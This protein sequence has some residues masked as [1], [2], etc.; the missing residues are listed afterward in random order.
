MQDF[1]DTQNLN[2]MALKDDDVAFYPGSRESSY[3]VLLKPKAAHVLVACIGG[4]SWLNFITQETRRVILIDRSDL[5]VEYCRLILYWID[6]AND[7]FDFLS[8]L[9]STKVDREKGLTS[10]CLTDEYE[11]PDVPA[12]LERVYRVQREWSTNLKFFEGWYG[13]TG[14]FTWHFGEDWPFSN[15]HDNESFLLVKKV[16]ASVPVEVHNIGMEEYD[17][18]QAVIPTC[19]TYVMAS[20]ADNQFYTQGDQ[21]YERVLETMRDKIIYVFHSWRRTVEL[22]PELHH[23]DAVRKIKPFTKNKVVLEFKTH[24]GFHFTDAELE[25]TKHVLADINDPIITSFR[26]TGEQSVLFYHISLAD[27][28][29]E[30]DK[31]A[32]MIRLGAPKFARIVILDRKNF[33]DFWLHVFRLN[34]MFSKLQIIRLDMSGGKRGV[35]RNLLLVMQMRGYTT[36]DQPRVVESL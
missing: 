10:A 22:L 34:D 26:K 11:K 16:L 17:Y 3:Y 12:D 29:K 9:S 7:I 4:M 20:N 33:L 31:I 1:E 15:L 13:K 36:S 23:L 32:D 24:L 18:S 25:S 35:D 14:V 28:R 8:S 19:R 2:Y 21:I 30:R 5:Q 6:K 27:P